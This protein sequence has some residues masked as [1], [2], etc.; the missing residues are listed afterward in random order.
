MMSAEEQ[1]QAAEMPLCN[2]IM[3]LTQIHLQNQTRGPFSKSFLYKCN[4]FWQNVIYLKHLFNAACK[5]AF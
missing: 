3:T 1:H 2:L 5:M 4:I